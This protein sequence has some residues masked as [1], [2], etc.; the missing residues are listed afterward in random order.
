[1]SGMTR[2]RQQ[3]HMHTH[4]QINS[5]FYLT[6]IWTVLLSN[7]VNW[8]KTPHYRYID[9]RNLLSTTSSSCKMLELQ[10]VENVVFLGWTSSQS[11][12]L[13]LQ[14]FNIK[15]GGVLAILSNILLEEKDQFAWN[16]SDYF[17]RNERNLYILKTTQV[18]I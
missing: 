4:M 13:S 12:V 18:L 3:Q 5:A 17:L 7:G 11:T 1:M 15:M 6:A 16:H 9:L 10:V 2:G 14:I 8:H